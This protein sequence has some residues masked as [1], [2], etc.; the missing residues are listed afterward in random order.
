MKYKSF[1]LFLLLLIPPQ[2]A[3]AQYYNTG[4]DPASLK[5]MQIKTGRFSVIYPKNYGAGGLEFARSLDESYSKLMALYPAKKFKIPIIIHNYSVKPNGYVSWAP[6]RMEIYPTPEQNTIPLNPVEQLSV[7][8]LTH[9]FQ[10]SSLNKGFSKFMS[11]ILGEQFTGIMATLLPIWFFEGQAVFAE[12]A[13]TQSGRGRSPSFQK[14]VKAIS[15]D[16][17]KMYKYDKVANGSYKDF[18][19][20]NYETGYQMVTWAMT[21][22]DFN[23]WNKTINYTATLP[24]TLNPV[25]IS[26]TKNTGL[27]KKTLSKETF[28]TLKTIWTKE[29]LENEAIA[30]KAINPDKKKEYINYLSPVITGAD[31][32]LAVKTTLSEPPAFVLLNPAEKTE[33]I[34]HV[35]GQ[36][37]PYFIS[38]AQGKIVWVETQTDLRWENRKYS[39]IKIMDIDRNKVKRLSKR[40]RYLA[41]TISPDGNRVAAIENTTGN[42]N[43]LVLVNSKNGTVLGT[44]NSPGNIH[45]QRPQWSENG[46]KISFIVLTG[47][48]EGIASFNIANNNWEML[49]SPAREDLQSSYLKN[50]SLFFVSSLSGTDNIYLKIPGKRT[51]ILTNSRFG[52]SDLHLK[53]EELYF[54]D[55][56]PAG[57][58]IA[59]IPVAGKE[60]KN[61]DDRDSSSYLINRI[62]IDEDTLGKSVD[63]VYKPVPYRKWKHLFNFH[64]WMPFYADLEEIEAD[65]SSIRP[66]V[67]V[68]TQN[69]L[70]TLVST[71]SYEYSAEK[72]HVFHTGVTWM[73]WYPVIESQ[74]D[75]GYDPLI[76]KSG[77]DEGPSVVQPGLRF[78]NTISLPLNFSAGKFTQFLRPSVT[79]DYRNNLIFI[80]AE[81]NYDSDQTIMSGRLF[82]SN[83]YRNALRDIYPKWGQVIDANYSFAPFDKDIYGTAFS[84]KTAF[85]FPGILPDNGIKIRFE[86]EIQDPTEFLYSNRASFPRGYE[87]IIS[88]KLDFFSVDY[89]LPVGYPDLNISSFL[90]LKRIRTGF[91]YDHATGTDNTYFQPDGPVFHGY[92]ETFQSYGLELL[93]DFHILRIPYMI[94]GGVQ[95]AWKTFN[96]KPSFQLLFTIDLFGYAIGKK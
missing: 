1:F 89:V 40:S 47:E 74:L 32:I 71:I 34:L 8:E 96:E 64:S 77:Q 39:V 80:P 14:Q 82:F 16:K 49:L 83:V 3:F 58:N 25:N 55:Y 53:G 76:Y 72:K 36:F 88:M 62:N 21:K 57:E 29:I 66:G 51:Q 95:S 7:H 27:K 75:Y 9:V 93:A 5:W 42:T 63:S 59:A 20:N 84:L 12:T 22:Y 56:T 6:R 48:G 41:A 23:I 15:V 17:G 70:S 26:L 61:D 60:I 2:S 30:Y 79:S 69:H 73:G 10:L 38:Y 31:S 18:V 33:K 43:K 67:T 44:F 46:E 13:L 19:P 94:S 24:F 92:E 52:A 86:K 54:S 28:D 45:L 50:D 78:I 65:P 37:Y 35:P 91:F 81:G 68:M 85:Y 87:N 11:V 90:Y 4:Q